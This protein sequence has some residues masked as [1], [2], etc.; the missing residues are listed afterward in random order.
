MKSATKILYERRKAGRSYK[1]MKERLNIS[2]LLFIL[3]LVSAGFFWIVRMFLI[4][5]VLAVTLTILFFPVYSRFLRWFRGR[6]NL[7]SLVACS[8]ALLVILLP[9]YGVVYL[10]A[11]ELIDLIGSFNADDF[12][13]YLSEGSGLLS[14]LEN[15]RVGQLLNL[16]RDDIVNAVRNLI[17]GSGEAIASFV[18]RMSSSILQIVTTVLITLFSMFYF[19][20]DGESIT[21]QVIYLMPLRPVYEEKLLE[22]FSLIARATIKG[23]LVIGLIQGSLGALTLLVFGI[24][25][26]PLWGVVMTILA[27]IPLLGPWLV[28]IPIGIVQLATGHV[29]SGILIIAISTVIVSTVD[30]FVRPRLVGQSSQVHDLLIFFSTLGGLAVCGVLGFIMGPVIA[31]LFVTVLEIYGMEFKRYLVHRPKRKRD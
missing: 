14:D 22:R 30:N 19:F 20:R 18:N 15:S 17:A 29:I 24:S 1:H 11:V 5:V 4:P 27:I 21:D 3:L 9:L 12:Q 10:V 31:A 8:I 26:W 7:S 13:R 25:A 28:L 6:K 23:T 16:N 2:F